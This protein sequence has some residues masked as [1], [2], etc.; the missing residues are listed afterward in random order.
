M[1][2]TD[3]DPTKN[4]AH[5]RRAFVGGVGALLIT[6]AF[7]T[8]AY[9]KGLGL[10]SILGKAS[11]GAL[12]KLAKPG[13]YY[14][15]K[16]IR[17]SLPLVGKVLGG[18]G[19]GGTLGQVLGSVLGGGEDRVGAISGLTRTIND[20]AGV[21][22]GE[23]KPIFRTA[24]DDLSFDDVPNIVNKQD[25]GTRYLRESSNDQLHTKLNPLVDTALGDL[26]AHKQLDELNA[27]YDWL[28]A[29]GI[30]RQ[31]LNKSVTD[32]GLDGIFKYMGREEIAFRK[33]P[34]GELGGVGRIL[35]DIF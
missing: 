16:D 22:A 15:D 35:K 12:N 26:G 32:Q 2:P 9:A 17:L 10:G 19:G 21:A 20:A 7:A 5:D 8:P 18:G 1:H 6:S 25:G 33:N 3:T 34:L 14:D 11:D 28:S 23:A 27:K 4:F 30:N 13:A 29:L 24:I 31:G